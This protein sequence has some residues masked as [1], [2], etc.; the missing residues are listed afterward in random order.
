MSDGFILLLEVKSTYFADS[1]IMLLKDVLYAAHAHPD[2][3]AANW[4][5]HFS[6]NDNE[7]V[8][9]TLKACKYQQF[10]ILL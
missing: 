3:I 10:P 6:I 8:I 5:W 7:V 2:V 4:A 1:R 9:G